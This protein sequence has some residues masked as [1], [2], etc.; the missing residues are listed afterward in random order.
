MQFFFLQKLSVAFIAVLAWNQNE[1]ARRAAAVQI[2][3]SFVAAAVPHT[4]HDK[5]AYSQKNW[6]EKCCKETVGLAWDT[7]RPQALYE[8][9]WGSN[10]PQIKHADG[11]N[12]RGMCFPQFASMEDQAH[13]TLRFT[14]TPQQGP[15]TWNS[16]AASVQNTG[17]SMR[18]GANTMKRAT[19]SLCKWGAARPFEIRLQR[20]AALWTP[21]KRGKRQFWQFLGWIHLFLNLNARGQT[22][23]VTSRFNNSPQNLKLLHM[24]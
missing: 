24:E 2:H 22:G 13:L 3:G 5:H 16:S 21:R 8:A 9:T 20:W 18:N 12:A 17:V 4:P 1:W 7:K 23:C 10:S 11:A 15:P 14:I 6:A 19:E